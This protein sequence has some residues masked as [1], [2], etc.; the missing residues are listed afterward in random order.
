[1]LFV[2]C[3]TLPTRVIPRLRCHAPLCSALGGNLGGCT[4]WLLGLDG[5]RTAAALRADVLVPVR[6]A[7]R[8]VDYNYGFG[9]WP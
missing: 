7:R 9:G 5:G 4:S 3:L 8:C 2:T 6:G 1:M